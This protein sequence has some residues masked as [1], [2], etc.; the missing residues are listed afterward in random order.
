MDKFL[1]RRSAFWARNYTCALDRARKKMG[2]QNQGARPIDT[3]LETLL[4]VLYCVNGT[5][6]F[7]F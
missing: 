2:S 6:S 5:Y 3:Q 7:D 4:F 1:S